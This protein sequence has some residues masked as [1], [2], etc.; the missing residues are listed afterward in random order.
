MIGN[1]VLSKFD[2]TIRWIDNTNPKSF[3]MIVEGAIY[4]K[5]NKSVYGKWRSNGKGK[6]EVQRISEKYNEATQQRK[7]TNSHAHGY[8]RMRKV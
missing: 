6:Q 7:K 3:K 2:L 4:K 1:C 5:P 8:T